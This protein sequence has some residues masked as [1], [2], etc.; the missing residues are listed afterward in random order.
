ML[1]ALSKLK[2]FLSRLLSAVL[3]ALFPKRCA[4][5]RQRETYLCD[6]CSSQIII[7][8]NFGDKTIFSAVSY[9]EPTVRQLVWLLK[10]R[11]V[12]EIADIFAGWLYEA[13]IED[14]AEIALYREKQGRILIIPIPLSKKRQRGRGYNQAEEIAK[15]LT[16]FDPKLFRLETGNLIKIKETKTQVSVKNRQDRLKNLRGVFKILNAQNLRGRTIILLD[17]VSTTGATMEEASKALA[18]GKPRRIIKVTVA[19]G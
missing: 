10:Y 15:K 12:R 8:G 1:I 13:L 16:E 19:G 2:D 18:R 3:D 14:L 11:G 5:C 7:R 17:D 6:R 4:G 9:H